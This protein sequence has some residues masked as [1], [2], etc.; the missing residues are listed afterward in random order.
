MRYD[1]ASPASHGRNVLTDPPIKLEDGGVLP[2]SVNPGACR[3]KFM[4][5]TEQ[6]VLP[7]SDWQP[8]SS[9]CFKVASFCSDCRWHVDITVDFRAAGSTRPCP[10]NDFPLHH[11]RYDPTASDPRPKPA[12]WTDPRQWVDRH[13]FVCSAPECSVVVLVT[14]RPPR[15][16]PE[17]LSLLVDPAQIR[18]RAQR[19]IDMAPE[20]FKNTGVP[21]PIVVLQNLKQYLTDA[22]RAKEVKQFP[23]ANKRFLTSLGK[24]CR[25]L[26]EYLGFRYDAQGHA[27]RICWLSS[28]MVS[29]TNECQEYG[30]TWTL[31]RVH[32]SGSAPTY[33]DDQSVL[34][35]DVDKEL[36]VLIQDRPWVERSTAKMHVAFHPLPAMKSFERCL[37]SLDCKIPHAL[38]AFSSVTD[39]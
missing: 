15:L 13:R 10:N 35:D 22:L 31:P 19:E 38:C 16:Q 27:V 34:V 30:G 8:N 14:Y 11:L 18:E 33:Q 23:A 37:G 36:M 5:K 2:I 20:R 21:E 6:S 32:G 3:H 39:R 9:S 7:P 24:P 17:H 1:P 25:P 12:N 29:N 26:L 28:V 4:L